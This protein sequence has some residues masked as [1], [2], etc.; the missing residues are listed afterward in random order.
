MTYKVVAGL[1]FRDLNV[2]NIKTNENCSYVRSV[3]HLYIAHLHL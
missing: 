3:A 2:S 1:R